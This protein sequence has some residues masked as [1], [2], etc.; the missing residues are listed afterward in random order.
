MLN[1]VALAG[2]LTADP[3]LRTTPSG[4]SVVSFTIAVDR[5]YTKDGQRE[6]DFIH[7]VA[8]R[9]TAEFIDRYF[10]KGDPICITGAIQTRRYEDKAGNKKT[11]FEVVAD[12]AYFFAGS[13]KDDAKNAAD[14][15][16]AQVSAIAQNTDF[17]EI[18]DDEDLPF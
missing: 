18:T 17:T 3:E 5:D 16:A 4:N 7:L 13:R 2:R 14:D 6:A 1:H 12:K 10:S 11:A 9:G 8:W 15:S